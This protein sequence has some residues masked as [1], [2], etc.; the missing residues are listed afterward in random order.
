M[1]NLRDCLYRL[2]DSE[3]VSQT[4]SQDDRGFFFFWELA[5][6]VENFPAGLDPGGKSRR[7]IVPWLRRRCRVG[8][9]QCSIV[10]FTAIDAF[11]IIQNTSSYPKVDTKQ[12]MHIV[13]C[14]PCNSCVL[15]YRPNGRITLCNSCKTQKS[16]D[17]DIEVIFTLT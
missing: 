12:Q 14:T 8:Y 6:G 5:D 3:P 1:D 17:K 16:D 2:T 9:A 7:Q 15:N 13:H 4:V 10:R 11:Q